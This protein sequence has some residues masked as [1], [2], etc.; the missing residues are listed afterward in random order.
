MYLFELRVLSGYMPRSGL[1]DHMVILFLV[2]RGTSILF[3][4]VAALTY[5][6]TNSVGGFPFERKYFLCISRFNCESNLSTLLH[7][8]KSCFLQRTTKSHGIFSGEVLRQKFYS[9]CMWSR[10]ESV[11]HS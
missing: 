6:P 4:I 11:S 2:F 5:I 7:M 1:L 9:H 10:E 3:S 8:Q